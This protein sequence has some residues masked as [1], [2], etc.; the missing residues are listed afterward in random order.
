LTKILVIS[1][2]HANLTALEAVLQDAGP[3][4]E[5]WCLGDVVG[6]GPDPNDCI[7]RLIGLPNLTCLMGN[8][9]M[10]AV[11][12]LVLDVFNHDARNSLIWQKKV[13]TA[14]SLDFLRTRPQV[15]QT[16]GEVSLVHGSPRDPV[17]EYVL[18]TAVALEN[19]EHFDTH[20]CFL[21]HTHY[22]S[23]FQYHTD[24]QRMEI[25]LPK[26]GDTYS[27]NG[28]AILNPG[29]VGQPRDRDTRAAYAIYDTESNTWQP[30]R[31]T[32]DIKEV[33]ERIIKAGLPARHAKR[34]SSGW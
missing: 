24:S 29:S 1:D 8:H 18:N 30:K 17:W 4:E 9:D 25:Q 16:R 33:Q 3:V 32:Y 13:L 15:L 28:R 7:L 31:V 2:I 23:I 20:W 19:L 10:A 12:G 27:M 22:Q 14:E 6:Y 5:T 11:G 21:G 26:P 34:L